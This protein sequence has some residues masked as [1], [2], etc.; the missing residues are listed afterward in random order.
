MN[1]HLDGAQACLKRFCNL[2]IAD[3][4]EITHHQETRLVTIKLLK[5]IP[6]A[7]SEFRPHDA[8]LRTCY[9]RGLRCQGVIIFVM[10]AP[11]AVISRT[12]SFRTTLDFIERIYGG[13]GG[14][15]VQPA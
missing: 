3:I 12:D 2:I 13:V 8:L 14:N 4:I 6:D 15:A 5:H 11:I 9:G 7:F 1:A 10:F